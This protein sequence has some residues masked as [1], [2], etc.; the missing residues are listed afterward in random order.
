MGGTGPEEVAKVGAKVFLT[1][2]SREVTRAY[3][4]WSFSSSSEKGLNEVRP[5]ASSSLWR[6]VL[7]VEAA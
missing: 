4:D 6:L 5:V 7:D 2:E 3:E 1:R